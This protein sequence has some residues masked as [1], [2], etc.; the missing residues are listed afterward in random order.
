MNN[1][2]VNIERVLQPVQKGKFNAEGRYECPVYYTLKRNGNLVT[3]IW[4]PVN[5]GINPAHFAKRGVVL[6]CHTED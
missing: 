1:K 2:R 3:K 6:G 4:L 5:N